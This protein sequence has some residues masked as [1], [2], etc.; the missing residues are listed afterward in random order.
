MNKENVVGTQLI[1]SIVGYSE[2]K[3]LLSRILI[4]VV[5]SQHTIFKIESNVSA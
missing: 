3:K 1:D 4:A 2:R 5:N